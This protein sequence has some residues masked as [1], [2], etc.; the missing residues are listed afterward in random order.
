MKKTDD[1][2][3]SKKDDDAE[4]PDRN[5]VEEEVTEVEENEYD[6]T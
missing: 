2:A 1:V 4:T 6:I 5:K 3:I